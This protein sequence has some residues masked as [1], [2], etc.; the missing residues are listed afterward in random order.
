[1]MKLRDKPAILI[2]ASERSGT[3]LLRSILSAHSRISSPPPSGMVS[4]LYPVFEAFKREGSELPLEKITSYASE[5]TQTHMNKWS[6]FP[7]PD[8]I[9]AMLPREPNFWDLFAAYNSY[10]LEKCGGEIWLSKEPGLMGHAVEIAANFPNAH[11]I[12]LVRDGRDV[13]VSMV[14]KRHYANTMRQGMA[15]WKREQ[16]GMLTALEDTRVAN[17]THTIRY[18]DLITSPEA[19]LSPIMESVGL[20]FEAS[21]LEFYSSSETI[22]HAQ[23]SIYWKEVAQPIKADNSRKYLEAMD[24]RELEYVEAEGGKVLQKLGYELH[25][26]NP[27]PIRLHEKL[28]EKLR[29]KADAQ[30]RDVMSAEEAEQRKKLADLFGELNGLVKSAKRG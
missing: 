30:P 14:R 24:G 15:R 26:A 23:S 7:D 2:L 22:K 5:L 27:R 9:L 11:F 17:M 29:E 4:A 25:N 19:V 8:D 21:Q 13:A 28:A 6:H 1:M 16:E 12:Y 20:E 3:N 10:Y 18:E